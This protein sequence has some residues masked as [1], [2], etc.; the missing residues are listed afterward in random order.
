MDASLHLSGWRHRIYS[1]LPSLLTKLSALQ[2]VV[3]FQ[4]LDIFLGNMKTNKNGLMESAAMLW[5]HT[6]GKST[7]LGSTSDSIGAYATALPVYP[8]TV[9]AASLFPAIFCT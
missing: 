9:S 4:C 7:P 3:G 8:S 1:I 2:Y 6:E 5:L